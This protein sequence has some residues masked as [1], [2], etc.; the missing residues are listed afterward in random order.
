MNARKEFPMQAT[1]PLNYRPVMSH[2]TTSRAVY[3]RRRIAVLLCAAAVFALGWV[4][5]HRLTG[6]SGGGPLTAPGQPV[7]INAAL[8]THTRVIVQP[9][10]TMWTIARRVQPSGDVRPL[11]SS[12]EAKRHGRPL[13]VGET[14]Q[15]GR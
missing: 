10:D 12:L 5:L 15:I 8:V 4:G 6:A 9:G 3:R 1:I 14:L 11:V 7:S 13:Q 2:R